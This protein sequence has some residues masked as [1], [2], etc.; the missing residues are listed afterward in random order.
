MRS[1]APTVTVTGGAMSAMME[2][3]EGSEQAV[4]TYPGDRLEADDA[5]GWGPRM[6]F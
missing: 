2:E 3:E 6:L 5:A 4:G 1:R